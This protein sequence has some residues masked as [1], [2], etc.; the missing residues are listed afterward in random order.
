M[1][2]W[3]HKNYIILECSSLECIDLN[4]LNALV[5]ATPAHL[6]R[7]RCSMDRDNKI[8]GKHQVY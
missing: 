7:S 3:K 1:V 2:F 4:Q 8:I 6:N 5:L